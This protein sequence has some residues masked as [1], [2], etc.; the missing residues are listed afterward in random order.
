MRTI[1]KK[2]SQMTDRGKGL[3][4]NTG[5]ARFDLVPAGAVESLAR[6][7]TKGAV[8]YT[9]WNW[10]KGM[11]WSTV[12]ASLERHL[13]AFKKGE[14][15]DPETGLLHV[16]HIAAN[17]AILIEYYRIHPQGDDRQHS[18]LAP[19]R[20]AL[21]VD[22]V[23]ADFTGAYTERYEL[24]PHPDAWQFDPLMGQR[25]AELEEDEEFWV[26]L[27]PC[28]DSLLLPFEP[29]AYISSRTCPKEWTEAW[30]KKYGYPA[31]PVFHTADKVGA[32]YS[33]GADVLVDDNFTTFQRINREK[34]ICCY[35]L[36]APHN[37]RYEVGHRRI[38]SLK[39]LERIL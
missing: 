37:E 3:R 12:L 29:V 27:E 18:Y 13:N 17:A 34:G 10:A 26:S 30:L 24:L 14:D 25:M 22:E 32:M 1:P 8:K 39:E 28:E 35:L 15:Y 33:V 11:P 9:E 6:V 2:F 19:P 20:I 7:M 4:E 16:E 5:K 38:N 31:A 36:S 21:D 23:L